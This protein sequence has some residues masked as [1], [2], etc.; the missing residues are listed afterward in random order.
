MRASARTAPPVSYL[1]PWIE[2]EIDSEAG[3]SGPAGRRGGR[4]RRPLV[5]RIAGWSAR[6]RA[7]AILGW[8]GFLLAAFISGQFVTGA[9]VQQYDPGQAGRAERILHRLNVTT[10][11]VES[12]LIAAAG[13]T[14]ADDPQIRQAAGQVVAALERLPR[15]AM[16]LRSPLGRAGRS[17]ISANGAAALVTFEVA[18][19]HAAADA[20]VVADL[21]A[22]AGVQ[23]RFPHLVVQEAGG[24]STDRAG[25]AMLGQDFRRAEVTSVPITLILLLVVFGALIAAAIPV[26]LAGSAVAATVWLLAVPGHW[27]PVDA[28]TSEIVLVIGMAVGVDYSLFYLRREREERAAGRTPLEAI[29]I[30]AATSGRAVVVS[31]LTVMISLAG[32]FLTGID[33]FT[34]ISFGTIMVIGV[35]VLGSLTALP[36]VLAWLGPWA[37]RGRIPL[38]GRKRR[39]AR[40]SR[41]WT[42]LVIRVV[43]K[44][45]LWGGIAALAMLA[46]AVPAFGMRLGNP[47][48]DLP[49]SL[50]TVH[51]LDEIQHDFPSRPAPA[52]VVVTGAD[53]TGPAMRRSVAALQARA[54]GRGAI[55]GP[56]TAAA[57][58]GGRAL[59]VQVPLAGNGTGPVSNAALLDLR[60]QVLPATIG[61]VR[62]TSYSVTGDTASSFDFKAMLHERTPIVLLAVTLLAVCILLIA[63]GSVVIPL[64]SIALNFLSVGAACGII[65]FIFQDGHLQGLLGFAAY[66]GIIPWIPLFMFVLLFG[67]SMDYHVFVLSRIHELRRGGASNPEAVIGGI[68][69]TA[70]VVTSAAVVMAAVFSVFGTLSMIDLKMLGVGLASAILIDATVVRGILLPACMIALGDHSWY[71]PRWLGWLPSAQ[72]PAGHAAPREVAAGHKADRV[73]VAAAAAQPAAV[74]AE[75]PDRVAAAALS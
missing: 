20:T 66:G 14:V 26:L 38:V 11:P 4:S 65:T 17:L 2:G 54:S 9:S 16:D 73:A 48:V 62:G 52:E 21:A 42:G 31:G 45:L 56:I 46:L 41:F 68:A 43:R 30:A 24:A 72:V 57:A 58:A 36:A 10:A 44:P 1:K 55:R 7:A 6:H 53:L 28:G 8:L 18:G 29:R 40:P 64:I 50:P 74:A 34:G 27:L 23:S 61:R 75:A 60:N 12:V 15:A 49:S 71:L 25:N 22:V 37:D 67:L 19:P 13:R 51:A 69:R 70:G 3:L 47:W 5:E 59:I 32:L 35:A 39:A 33:I 63:F